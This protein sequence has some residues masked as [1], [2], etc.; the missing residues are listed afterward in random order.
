MKKLAVLIL[1]LYSVLSIQYSF[2]QTKAENKTDAQGRKQGYWEKVDP[3]TKKI[4][5]KGT[6]KD[7]KPQGLFVYYYKGT[8][9]V[10]TKM[11]FRQDGKFAYAQLFH[12]K[13]KLQA[14]GKYIGEQKDSVWNFYDED[15][16]L[17]STEGYSNGKKNG[18]SKVFFPSGKVSEEKNY[19]NG[20]LDG[21]FKQYFMDKGIVKAEGSYKNDNY[22]GKCAWYYPNGTAAAQGIY[23]NG[24]KKGIWL[25]K[26][27]DG[28][29]KDKEVWVNGKQ[30]SPKEMEEYFKKNKT[31]VENTSDKKT[32]KPKSTI[33][34]K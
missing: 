32:E 19:K 9:S 3:S 1:S 21:P 16:T 22:N 8:D 10:H 28:K 18:V 4:I 2:A 31:L 15:G 24:V 11:D 33:Q 34:K 27:Q 29:I 12:L 5:Y 13:G 25:Y 23:D 7:D 20:L 6:F 30:L 14:K 26:D 17:L